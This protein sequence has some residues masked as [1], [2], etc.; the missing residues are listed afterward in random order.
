[1]WHVRK[2]RARIAQQPEAVE[3]TAEKIKKPNRKKKAKQGRRK[4]HKQPPT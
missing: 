3:P 2:R 1:M 4:K